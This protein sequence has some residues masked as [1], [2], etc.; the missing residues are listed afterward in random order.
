MRNFFITFLML[1][2]FSCSSSKFLLDLN[3]GKKIDKRL[4]GKW[5]GLDD[6]PPA[7]A[8]VSLSPSWRE[9]LARVQLK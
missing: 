1:F 4:V 6:T 2:V 5:K 8:S 9:R 3:N 7:G